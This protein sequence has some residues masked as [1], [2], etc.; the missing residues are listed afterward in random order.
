MGPHW[1]YSYPLHIDEWFAIG[2]TQSTIESGSLQYSDPYRPGHVSFHPEM[3]FH[4][5]LGFVNT[6]TGLSWMGLYRIAPGVV[7]ALLA[8]LTYAFGQRSGFGWAA[9]LFVPLIP[10]SIRTLGPAF[11]VPVSAAM[12]FIPVT[13]LV[14][15]TTEEDTRGKSLWVLLLLVSDTLFVHP[16]TEVVITALAVLF[17]AGLVLEA[18]TRKEYGKGARLLLAIGVRMLIPVVILGFWLP[19]LSQNVLDQSATNESGIAAIFGLHTGFPQAFGIVAVAVSII[20]LFW[21][22]ARGDGVRSYVLPLFTLLLLVFLAF[23][24]PRYQLGPEILYD[25]GWSFLG[26]FMA[27]FAGFGVALYFRNVPLLAQ[28]LASRLG[29][30]SGGW[31]AA[32]LG[33]LGGGALVFALATGLITNDARRVYSGYY[34]IVDESI[35]ADFFWMGQHTAP[36]RVVALGEPTMAWAYPPVAGPGSEVF[37][38]MSAPWSNEKTKKAR[39]MLALGEADG[40]WLKESGISL[41][42]TC[43]PQTFTCAEL[44]N[45]DLFKVRRGVYLVPG[46]AEIR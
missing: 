8:F 25:R 3:G 21:F 14:L 45:T 22:I 4:L 46:S 20:G 36:G 44:T 35:F 23:F 26:L 18:V 40:P 10:T 19:S 16:P 33:L 13:L 2:Y 42:Y 11:L 24:F 29:R 15:N 43:V 38:A 12:L 9:A 1:D 28:T 5:L 41:F 37:Q 6:V 39:L 7:L 17:L 34:H 30:W 31:A 27:I 32:F